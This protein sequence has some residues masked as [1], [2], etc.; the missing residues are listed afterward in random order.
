MKIKNWKTFQHFK[1]RRPPWI[2]LHREI[3]DNRDIMTISDCSFRVLI[4]LWL[5]ASED[6]SLEG[7]LPCLEDVQFRLRIDKP[8]LAK[9]LRDLDKFL[10]HDD[11]SSI[12]HQVQ[13]G[14]PETETETETE[15]R[16]SGEEAFEEFRKIYPG[17]KRGCPT[18]FSNF[19]RKH[20]DW[21]DALPLLLPAIISQ[22]DHHISKE[23]AGLWVPDTWAGLS[24]WINQRRWEEV[25]PEVKA[26][27][28]TEEID[29]LKSKPAGTRTVPEVIKVSSAAAEEWEAQQHD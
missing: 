10:I 21:K 14:P 16:Q 12:S 6:E 3:L 18:E 11:I 8:R 24:V 26:S 7:T 29:M 13:D 4:G 22:M 27:G 15:E 25:L 28:I 2:K 23:R 20:S 1:D 9:A 5:L 19:Q 17:K